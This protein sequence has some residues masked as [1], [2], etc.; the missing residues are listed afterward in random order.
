MAEWLRRVTAN[1]LGI[2]GLLKAFPARVRIPLA[3]F[4]YRLNT[5]L[6]QLFTASFHGR[7]VKAREVQ[8][9]WAH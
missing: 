8:V 1:R 3:A 5:D 9:S 4:L 6:A 7:V 2:T